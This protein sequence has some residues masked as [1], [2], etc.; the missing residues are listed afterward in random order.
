MSSGGTEQTEYVVEPF[1]AADVIAAP[2]VLPRSTMRAA[3]FRGDDR[4]ALSFQAQ[5]ITHVVRTLTGD[6]TVDSVDL[7]DADSW[8]LTFAERDTS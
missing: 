5:R 1:D 7:T 8:R 2:A 3:G 4:P 6:W